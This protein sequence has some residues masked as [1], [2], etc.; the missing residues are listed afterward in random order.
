MTEPGYVYG[1]DFDVVRTRE[2]KG[3]SF[4]LADLAGARF[5]DCELVDVRFDDCVVHD[6]H[7]N[8]DVDR[9]VVND[10]DVTAY[11]EGELDR[12]YPERVPIRALRTAT[13]L[14]VAEVRSI[15]EAV[16]R[17]WS[18]LLARADRLPEPARQERVGGEWSITEALRHL[19]FCIDAWVSRTVLDQERPYHPLG[20]PAGGYPRDDAAA[21]GLDLDA[22]PTYAEAKQ[23]WESRAAVL[24]GALAD[25]TDADLLRPCPRNPA[26]GYPEEAVP[27]FRCLR[28]ALNEHCEHG[29]Y[30][31]RDLTVLESRSG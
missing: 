16:D 30:A 20:F 25:L 26:P 24:R 13:A 12:R 2:L 10:V 31:D 17:R 27:V 15:A 6:V 9:L 28:V 29:R 18:E 3:K 5:R 7:L 1:G 22:T 21:I 14:R 23:A 11:V 19:T 8:G 4:F